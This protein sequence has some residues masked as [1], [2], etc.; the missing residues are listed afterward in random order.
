[1]PPVPPPLDAQTGCAVL[2]SYVDTA[3]IWRR[4]GA[5]LGDREIIYGNVELKT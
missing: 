3:H 1:M 5:A 2:R 4:V